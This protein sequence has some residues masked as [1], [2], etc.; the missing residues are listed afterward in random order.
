MRYAT[1]KCVHVQVQ[2]SRIIKVLVVVSK[3]VVKAKN[4]VDDEG[5]GGSCTPVTTQVSV[6]LQQPQKLNKL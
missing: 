3:N 4:N 2:K 5:Q 6:S 1:S